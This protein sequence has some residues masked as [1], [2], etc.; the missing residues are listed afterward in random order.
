MRY[1]CYGPDEGSTIWWDV[2]PRQRLRIKKDSGATF[3][4]LQSMREDRAKTPAKGS[5]TAAVKTAKK[6][7]KRGSKNRAKRTSF[8]VAKLP[9]RPVLITKQRI[10]VVDK[11]SWTTPLTESSGTCQE[12]L[13]L[14]W[15]F[16]HG[17]MCVRVQMHGDEVVTTMGKSFSKPPCAHVDYIAR[18]ACFGN[19]YRHLDTG[20]QLSGARMRRAAGGREFVPAALGGGRD[21][22]SGH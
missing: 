1:V 19:V 17:R 18:C 2:I 9:T 20:T 10:N 12:A 13:E 11:N 21:D 8:T 4:T 6:S 7:A 3:P 22:R 5:A 16:L 14:F 15:H